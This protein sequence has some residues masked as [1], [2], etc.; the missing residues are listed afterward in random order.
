MSRKKFSPFS[1]RETGDAVACI[2][3]NLNSGEAVG[4]RRIPDRPSSWR[5]VLDG[6]MTLW[7]FDAFGSGSYASK[8]VGFRGPT[9][10]LCET[11]GLQLLGLC[12]AYG[13]FGG[14][15]LNN[16]TRG[17]THRLILSIDPERRKNRWAS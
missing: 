1:P 8:R 10:V 6:F 7:S 11:Q 17:L 4:S 12:G 16:G 14:S 3:P 2:Q 5:L 15:L 9:M 13:D